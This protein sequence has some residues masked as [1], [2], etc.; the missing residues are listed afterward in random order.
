MIEVGENSVAKGADRKD[1]VDFVDEDRAQRPAVENHLVDE[2]QGEV[3]DNSETRD[4]RPLPSRC[5]TR[6]ESEATDL[7]IVLGRVH[8]KRHA[9]AADGPTTS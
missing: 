4:P 7:G 8:R 5:A 3:V 6:A 1:V 9:S 2:E